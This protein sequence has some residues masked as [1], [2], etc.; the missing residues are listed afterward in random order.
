MKIL[1]CGGL[2]ISF[3][4]LFLMKKLLS[5]IMCV[6]GEKILGLRGGNHPLI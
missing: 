4:P 1:A 5:K 3:K 6:A 2:T